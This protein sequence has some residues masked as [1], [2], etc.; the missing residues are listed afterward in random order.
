MKKFSQAFTII[1]QIKW[2]DAMSKEEV[3]AK[4]LLAKMTLE[5]KVAQL[6]QTVAGYR[7]YQRDG[8]NFSFNQEFQNFIAQYG[9]MGAI[10]NILRSCAWTQKDWGIGIEPH[11]RVKVANQLQKY[12]MENTR[13]GIPVLIEAEANHGI[14]ALGSEMF[15]TNIGMGC[16]FNPDLYGKVM[17][18]VGKEMRLSGNHMAFVTMFDL[19][20]DPRW[21][22]CE[23]F[24]SEDPY[25]AAQYAKN[26]VV[27]IKS[28]NTLVCCK[29]YC[30]TG[31]CAG[32]INTA[33]VNIGSRELHEV[34]LAPVAAAVE[35]GADVI[36]AAYNA[37]D[38]IPCHVNRYLL[39]DILRG[40]L[41]FNGI[42]LSDGW[43]V[44]RM[45][46]QMGYDMVKGSAA[47]LSAGIDLS[48]ADNGAFLNLI[49]ACRKGIVSE[50]LIDSAVLRI[51][52]K[53]Y[54]LG[55]FENPY[56][57]DDGELASYLGSGEQKKLSYQAATESAV[58]LKNNGILPISPNNKIAL[59]GA[60]ADNVYYQLGDYTSLRKTGEGKT[61][62]EVFEN[63]F[64]SVAYADGW[65]FR[66]S[67]EGF[68]EAMAAAEQS[69]VIIIAL[70]GS[71]ARAITEVE[72]DQNTGAAIS[73]SGFLD[74]GEGRDL[75]SVTLPGSQLEM[76]KELKSLG[77]PIIVLLI[78]GR[79]YEITE[80][81]ELSDA[82]LAAWYPG[83]Q[84]AEAIFDI[85]T[86]KVNPS[87]KLSVSI[88][89]SAA[90]L[91]AYYNRVGDVEAK[92]DDE[93][94]TNAYADYPNRT[95]FPF[96]YG[97]SY[98]SFEYSDIQARE[99]AKNE[100]EISAL[101]ENVSDIAGKEV[102]QLYIHGSGNSVKRRARELK[103]FQKIFL[104]PREKK[105]VIFRLGYDELKIYSAKEQFEVEPGCVEIFVGGSSEA[106]LK[107][108][109]ETY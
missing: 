46:R 51:L 63:G 20:R 34:H 87:G 62:R 65:D 57:E 43:G 22:R 101:V 18:S 77:K 33:E 1:K 79:P 31:D 109:V 64:T 38:G 8:E 76:L 30:A 11:Q 55:L 80:V 52:A 13:L 49:E 48:L 68:A 91:P 99:T 92:V 53:K 35:S 27:G 21:G 29:H 95:L 23:E 56:I 98:S 6:S 104:Q 73:S 88:P 5:E 37:V 75:A 60:H 26:G 39:R 96:G 19:A 72:Y 82:V 15:P 58:L 24:F 50:E 105:R 100:F 61:I 84:G 28:E 102:V 90:C 10:S 45:I 107:T 42:I 106:E 12:V 74:C 54:Q 14:Q 16:M 7:C 103:G 67:K 85:I 36:M 97:L 66:G 81:C 83:Q 86:G 108:V 94:C 89:Y 41:G 47:A 59:I 78:Q 71:T 2:G 40:E 9:A 93:C 17:A 44:E 69:D 32:G 4:E 70:G 3:F 25:L